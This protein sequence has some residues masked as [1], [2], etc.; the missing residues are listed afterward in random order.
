MADLT[1]THDD[2][3][4]RDP[5]QDGADEQAA[6]TAVDDEADDATHD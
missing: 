3:P 2:L 1:E 5:A 4:R 6:A